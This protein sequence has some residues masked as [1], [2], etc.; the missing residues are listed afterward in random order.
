MAQ[1]LCILLETCMSTQLIK[2]LLNEIEFF[3]QFSDAEKEQLLAHDDFSQF[4]AQGRRVIIEGESDSS[5]Y[6]LLSG[7]ITIS[8]TDGEEGEKIL[9]T[10]EKGAIF[11][12]ISFL[13]AAP[14]ASSATALTDCTLLK[15]DSGSM[16]SM[17]PAVHI[18]IKDQLI[19]I[20]VGRLERM[21]EKTVQQEKTIGQLLQGLRSQQN[22]A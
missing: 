12:E 19:K 16:A 7:S 6:V 1:H 22:E 11:G 20:L 10:L 21:N 15:I 3:W 8:K 2:K 4:V 14:R 17:D 9:A 5:L 18:R 13:T